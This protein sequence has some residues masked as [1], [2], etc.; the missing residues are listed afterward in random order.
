MGFYSTGMYL[1]WGVSL[2]L[3][4]SYHSTHYMIPLT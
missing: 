4:L 2:Y 1:E 3:I